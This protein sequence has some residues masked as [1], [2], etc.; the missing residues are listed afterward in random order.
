MK[1]YAIQ[2]LALVLALVAMVTPLPA[3]PGAIWNVKVPP[4]ASKGYRTSTSEATADMLAAASEAFRMISEIE[5]QRQN[6]AVS[7]GDSAVASLKAASFSFR[8][9][10]EFSV[11]VKLS[12]TFLN[13]DYPKVASQY[14]VPSQ[15]QARVDWLNIVSAARSEGTFGILTAGQNSADMLLNV[16]ASLRDTTKQSL[17]LVTA[18]RLIQTVAA[19]NREIQKGVYASALYWTK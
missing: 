13:Q 11:D 5:R 2:R 19:W 10:R 12:D 6:T 17:A 15:G 8:N 14:H 1:Y 3:S 16:T 9:A 4:T 18:D 7:A